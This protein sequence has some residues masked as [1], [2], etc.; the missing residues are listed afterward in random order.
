MFFFI[1]SCIQHV[2]KPSVSISTHRYYAQKK[3]VKKTAWE[4]ESKREKIASCKNNQWKQREVH[5]RLKNASVRILLDY[6]KDFLPWREKC[7]WLFFNWIKVNMLKIRVH[8]ISCF[9]LLFVIRIK[10]IGQILAKMTD[11]RSTRFVFVG[12]ANLATSNRCVWV[13]FFI[14]TYLYKNEFVWMVNMCAHENALEKERKMSTKTDVNWRQTEWVH[15]YVSI[16][17]D[18]STIWMKFCVCKWAHFYSNGK[19][20]ERDGICELL[21]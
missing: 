10:F 16:M 13:C 4:R 21:S 17:D 14:S 8:R 7:I 9:W 11:F 18:P 12:N 19:T 20:T 15:V 1:F 6:V 5:M 3:N 2:Y